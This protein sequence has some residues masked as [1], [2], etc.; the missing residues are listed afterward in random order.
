VALERIEYSDKLRAQQTAEIL[1]AKLHPT[2][3]TVEAPGL[4]PQW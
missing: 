1:A 2:D 4:A 3:G